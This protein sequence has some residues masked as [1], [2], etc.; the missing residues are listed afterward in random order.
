MLAAIK[1]STGRWLLGKALTSP[2][3][4]KLRS[5]PRPLRLPLQRNR[6][7]PV[8][9]LGVLRSREPVS[10]RMS[11]LG[12]TVWLVSGYAEVRTV[13]ADTSSYSNDVRGLAGR[14][15]A[16]GADAIGGL[17]FT[18]PPDHTRLRKYLTPEFT[19]RR[20][21]RL[22]P[23]IEQIVEQQ[24][25]ATAAARPVA[26]LV[27]TFAFPI[28]FLVICELLGLASDD[29][30][31]FRELGDARFDISAG[32]VGLLGA[33]TQS[34]EFLIDVVS[35]QRSNPGDGLIGALL[36]EHGAEL[37]DVELGGLAD[38]VFTGG[39][40]TSASMLA[41]GSS[42]LLQH[43]EILAA[44]RTDDAALDR[45]VEEL[46]RYLSVVQVAFPRFAKHDMELF[47]Q[48]VSAGDVV[49]CSLSGANRDQVFGATADRFDPD[50]S[51]VSHLAFGH[52]FHRCVGAELG[53]LELR[54][55]LRGLARRFPDMQ[56]A[57]DRSALGYRDLSLV[58]GVDSL[59]VHVGQT[60]AVSVPAGAR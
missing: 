6:L 47:G 30:D 2:Y 56:L 41:L 8:T 9:E 57:R 1:H 10:K 21:S 11:V 33:M 17:G 12:T 35:R 15:D 50:R 38:G 55:G 3:L 32:G 48:Q 40:E 51:S 58:Y 45:V 49:V 60:S 39:Y 44:I 23:R 34:R 37:D 29:R 42:V 14:A 59:P 31:G 16:T 24:L 19:K 25:D 5:V 54:L 27:E 43:P 4:A 28:P 52:G 13:L 22:A 36:T 18:D 46:L 7:D 53:R 26:D 20:L